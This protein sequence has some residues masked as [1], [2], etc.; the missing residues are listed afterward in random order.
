MSVCRLLDYR[1][2]SD[3]F[4]STFPLSTFSDTLSCSTFLPMFA[5]ALHTGPGSSGLPVCELTSSLAPCPAP[6]LRQAPGTASHL[7]VA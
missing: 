1:E 5:L 2:N 7:P 4:P 6:Y 3:S